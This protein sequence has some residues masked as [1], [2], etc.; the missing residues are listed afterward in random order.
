MSKRNSDANNSKV[1]Q[2]IYV[3]DKGRCRWCYEPVRFKDM[4]VAHGIAH[5]EAPL[6]DYIDNWFTCCSDCNKVNRHSA[7]PQPIP[8]E[9]ASV[10]QLQETNAQLQAVSGQLQ[11]MGE[12]LREL[13]G[14]VGKLVPKQ[15]APAVFNPYLCQAKGARC[16]TV[17]CQ[18]PNCVNY[19]NF[20]FNESGKVVSEYD[21]MDERWM[22]R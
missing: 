3:R 11:A 17:G 14:L 9:E 20:A 6:L 21:P 12:R 18:I 2:L 7:P 1:R 19:A 22:R 8:L 4:I 5:V 10:P 16:E 15:E 13:G